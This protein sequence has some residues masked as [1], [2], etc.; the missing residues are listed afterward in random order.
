MDIVLENQIC[1]P[2]LVVG[3]NR[4][5]TKWNIFLKARILATKIRFFGKFE[6]VYREYFAFLPPSLGFVGIYGLLC[7]I[8]G[9]VF[10]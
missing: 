7:S 1:I 6:L 3:F 5:L 8:L 2:Y 10:Y 9:V 4:P